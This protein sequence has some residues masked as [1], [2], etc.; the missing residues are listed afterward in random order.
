MQNLLPVAKNIATTHITSGCYRL[1][2][3]EWGIGEAVG[4]LAR[5]AID[6]HVPPIAIHREPKR[7]QALLRNQGTETAWDDG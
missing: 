4:C 6:Q 2:P 3:V 5:F 1:H 7:L